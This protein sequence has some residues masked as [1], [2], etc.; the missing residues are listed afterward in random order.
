MGNHPASL[1]NQMFCGMIGGLKIIDDYFICFKACRDSVIKDDGHFHFLQFSEMISA[2]RFSTL[3]ND[4]SC[5]HIVLQG[6]SYFLFSFEGISALKN[7][8]I[9]TCL[10]RVFLN[11]ANDE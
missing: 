10:V 5:E 8:D 7:G 4:D 3:A 11:S 9:I 2:F 6:F 1:F